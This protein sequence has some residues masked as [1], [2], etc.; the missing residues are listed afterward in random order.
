M[1]DKNPA[2]S[3]QQILDLLKHEWRTYPERFQKLDPEKQ[4][5]FL[6]QQ[7]YESF[8]DLMAHI[9]AWWQEAIEIINS[10]LDLE[11]HKTRE[12]DLDQFNAA[13]IQ[14]YRGWKDADLLSHYENL[15]LALVELVADLP[16]DGLTNKRINN[17][18]HACVVEHLHDHEIS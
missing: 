13:A 8:H 10:I 16:E 12:Y 18:L 1:T 4:A 5:A 2:I 7:G 3:C 6:K 14:K 17:W 15:R 9:I 11:E